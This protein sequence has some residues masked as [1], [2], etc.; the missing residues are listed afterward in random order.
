MD[1]FDE[2]NGLVAARHDLHAG[3]WCN[4]DCEPVSERVSGWTIVGD[5]DDDD[6]DDDDE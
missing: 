3:T 2:T 4:Q 5:D 6:D 1:T